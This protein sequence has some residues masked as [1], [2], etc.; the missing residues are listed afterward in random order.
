MVDK[1]EY[2][3]CG[4]FGGVCT[5]L[6][7]HPLDTVKV[8]LQTM[9]K[10]VPGQAPLYSGMLDCIRKTVAKEGV[11]G[12][13][14]GIGAPL[15]SVPPMCAVSFMGYGLG[16]SIF[17]VPG[18]TL[19]AFQD[20]CSGGVAGVF[21]TILMTPGERVKCLLQ[22]QEGSGKKLYNGSLDCAVKLYKEGGIKNLYKGTVATLMRD[23]PATGLYYLT[24]NQ[25]Q[26]YSTDN[27]KKDM[28]I[29][30][31][32]VGGGCAGIANW[33]VA[34]PADVIKSRLQT[35]TGSATVLTIFKDVMQQDGFLGLYK[36]IA[37]VLIR[38]FP[39]NAACFLGFELCKKFLRYFI[40][41]KVGAIHKALD[42]FDSF[43][44]DIYRSNWPCIRAGLLG[45]Q[46][47]VAV[48]NNYGNVEDT[49]TKLEKNGALNMRT[50]FN[51]EKGYIADAVSKKRQIRY[52]EKI[53]KTEE[54]VCQTK[55]KVLHK[56]KTKNLSLEESLSNAHIDSSRLINEDSM[57]STSILSQ[58]LPA[59]RIKGKEGWIMES[60][61][62]KYFD[63]NTSV[64]SI[65]EYDFHFP[66][67]LNVYCYERDNFSKFEGPKRGDTG[68]YNYYLMDGG[69]VLP[70][71]ALDIKPGDKVLDMC[72]APGGKS[73][74]ALQTLY[75]DHLVCN[76]LSISRVNRILNVLEQYFYDLDEKWMKTNRLKVIQS[77]GR[78]LQ[79]ENY[80]RVLVDVPCTTDRISVTENDNNIFKPGRIK[81]RLKLPEL[82]SEL[83][84]NGMK[85]VKKGGIVVYSTCSLSPIQNDGV[86]SMALKRIWE[87]TN[88]EFI[89]KDMSNAL[90]QVQVVYKL[91]D[92]NL[93]KFGHLVLP[94]VQQNYGPTYFYMILNSLKNC[95][96]KTF[97]RLNGV[98]YSLIRQNDNYVDN[99]KKYEDFKEKLRNGP[100]LQQFFT[101]E[102]T[103]IEGASKPIPYLNNLNHRNRKVY[104]D[105]YGC[106]MN[107]NDAEIIWSILKSNKYL[108]TND[109]NDADVVLI[110]TC[111]I[112]EG[113][114]TKIW[115]RLDYL[116]GIRNKRLRVKGLHTKIGILG[117]MAELAGPD[118]YKDLPYL[119]ASSFNHQVAINV[120]LS[121]DETYAD[122][123]PVRMNENAV[124]GFISIMRGCD[125]MCT[126]CIV[127]F[128]RGRERSRP[129][130]SILNEVRYLCE[131]GIK[132]ITLLGQNVNSY[133][134]LT[135]GDSFYT[136]KLARGFKTV[137][138]DKRGG[139]RF[140]TLLDKVADVNPEVRI[141]FTSPHPKDFP[142]EVLEVIRN[143][144]NVCNS[145]HLPA[146]SGNSNVLS[147]M[148]RGYTRE[149]YLELVDHIRDVIPN[150]AL[151]SDFICGFCG[152]TE[153]EF[154]DTLSLMKL[155]QYNMAYLFS[156]SMREKTTA[157]RRY[158]D[159]VEPNVKKSR[160]QL[161]IEAFRTSVEKI[162]RSQIGQKQLVLIE[163]K[164]K[165]SS[166]YL[167]GR[168]E[169]NCKVILPL[170]EVTNINN[171][172]VNLI[173]PGDYVVVQIEDANSQVLKGV[174]L[175][176][177]TLSEFHGKQL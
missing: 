84:L 125:N 149:T 109:L 21:S 81:E 166:L 141:R 124:T 38:A 130:E 165:R 52:L 119:L 65:K 75:L 99:S 150:V 39:A 59:T 173:K 160:L 163:D 146:Q 168:N 63:Q 70:V 94:S 25:F 169:G 83:L 62:I 6:V 50:L 80:D 22:I 4:G 17:G 123:M 64:N 87:E 97:N 137:Y 15:I 53:W 155:V 3:I 154:A 74:L 100:H 177:T 5:V 86:V 71:L 93:M 106:Q 7:G 127:P 115:N 45:K 148:R 102:T 152:E 48:I 95:G 104:F 11:F 151:S 157:H 143:R 27:G 153:D 110:I 121:A 103:K 140:A 66:E 42:H 138:K 114:E 111:A 14:K 72:A 1:I 55:S 122:I 47:Y 90:A 19:T 67:H 172:E 13:Y 171:A 156:Y 105:I 92:S 89:V 18:T 162:N 108:K 44:K 36:G 24:Y 96:S 43:Y 51:L 129:T 116:K 112:R 82:Q 161:M 144:H 174:P 167:Q 20:L 28:N 77:D 29:L 139:A 10:V 54:S 26:I 56:N 2:F 61:H 132:E 85:L 40:E 126:Y 49:I 33:I 12:L 117:C 16:K 134:D 58:F 170:Q 118:S 9:P 35:S 176:R 37:P 68:V 158:Q 159:D 101:S 131:N 73:L 46:K 41:K 78:L 34:M 164:S 147:R 120:Q 60:D 145:L 32:I 31:T 57:L 135:L 98:C 113:A 91:A 69:S 175:Y 88:L 128:T 8:R 136:T 107:T 79:K 76:D 23:V 30:L 133:R 142:D